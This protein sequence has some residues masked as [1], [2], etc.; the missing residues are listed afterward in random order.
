MAEDVSTSRADDNAFRALLDASAITADLADARIVGGQMVNLLTLIYPNAPRIERRTADADLGISVDI[1]SA[2]TIHNRLVGA[3][4][5]ASSGNHYLRE[6]AEI[7]VL[8]PA[9]GG[10]FTSGEISGRGIDLA[11]GLDLALASE[12][13]E[14]ELG[15]T[16]LNTTFESVIV[17][18]PRVEV[19]VVLK[20]F[21]TRSRTEA[22]D[23]TDLY[24]LLSIAHSYDARDIG[25]WALAGDAAG[26]GTRLDCARTLHALADTASRSGA[27]RGS[28]VPTDEFVA[29]IRENVARPAR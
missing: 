6:G 17:R 25:G 28:E 12:P 13:I 2:G 1:A 21:A 22:K 3:G 18:V 7:D 24:N 16:F 9:R 10:R 26:R 29:L 27:L 8:A 23:I 4:Y 5:Q 14:I 19:A 20:A 11:P 15:L